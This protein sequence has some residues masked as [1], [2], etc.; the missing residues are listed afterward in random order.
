MLYDRDYR[1][2]NAKEELQLQRAHQYLASKKNGFT[3]AQLFRYH[4][5]MPEA[6]YHFESIFPN[7]YLNI[8]ELDN[9]D[10]LDIACTSFLSL[11]EQ[12]ATE[13]EIINLINKNKYYFIIGSILKSSYSFGY[14]CAYAIKE[15]A[16]P[17]NFIADYLLIDKSS[18]GHQLVFVELESPNGTIVNADG[19]FGNSIR[20]GLKQIED[21]DEWIDGNFSH[22]R[23]QFQKY[24]GT[25][26]PLPDELMTLD[27]TRI[28]YTIVA[29]RRKD[30]KEKT[31]R[32][33]RK[34][35]KENDITLLHYDNLIDTVQLFKRSGNY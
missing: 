4:K 32:L 7:N 15:F 17:P 23:L 6:G 3:V 28:H 11:I 5:M 22:L 8:D 26:T 10:R 25:H 34:L 13:R 1:I 30:F 19:T 18:S 2:L 27:K 14:H 35:K 31:Y 12:Q 24:L 33:Q 20:K 21:W 29:G 16:L 9:H